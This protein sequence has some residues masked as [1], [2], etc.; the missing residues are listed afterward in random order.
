MGKIISRKHNSAAV[1]AIGQDN[2]NDVLSNAA[3]LLAPEATKLGRYGWVVDPS[4]ACLMSIYI[5]YTWLKTGVEQVNM[6][7]G[8]RADPEFL[9]KVQAIAQGH[10]PHMVFD[11][12]CAYH[13]GP[14]LLVELEMVMPETTTLLESHDVG[15]TLQVK[16][17]ALEEVERCFVHIDYRHREQ[18]DHDARVPVEVKV[19]SKESAERLQASTAPVMMV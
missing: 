2:L 15:I 1:E 14:K 12:L 3:A 16:I 6:I 18:D 5:I 4:A 11:K 8:K 17:E 13:F 9:Q 10:S 19:R 7:V